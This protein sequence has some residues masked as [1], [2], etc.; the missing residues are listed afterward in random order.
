MKLHLA[1]VFGASHSKPAPAAAVAAGAPPPAPAIP[2]GTDDNAFRN[3]F[4]QA[5]PPQSVAKTPS[6]ST[7]GQPAPAGAATNSGQNF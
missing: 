7:M 6:A 5:Y 1:D 4:D 2:A 3:E